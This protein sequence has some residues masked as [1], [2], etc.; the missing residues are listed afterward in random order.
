MRHPFPLSVSPT[1]L[2]SFHA[3]PTQYKY[4]YVLRLQESGSSRSIHLIAGSAFARGLE[5]MRD[6]YYNR[7]QPLATAIIL[8]FIALTLEYG[9]DLNETWA[10][11]DKSW[12][13]TVASYLNYLDRFPPPT[14]SLQPLATITT[15]MVEFTFSIPSPVLHPETGQPI[16]IS[17]RMDWVGTQGS[18]IWGVD[19]KTTK[20]IGAGWATNWRLRGQF[21]CYAW[22][23]REY[24]YKAQGIWVR[25]VPINAKASAEQIQEAMVPVKEWK[26]EMWVQQMTR[27]L[28]RMKECWRTD[29]WDQ[30]LGKSCTS[31]QQLENGHYIGGCPFQMLCDTPDPEPWISTFERKPEKN[32]KGELVHVKD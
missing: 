1:A 20:T 28:E 10:D 22:A 25:G 13:N 32:L 18:L 19:E 3:C 6:A 21:M 29:A 9:P 12:F 23:L 15:R 4:S 11:H 31:F 26:L 8:G 17:G 30:D 16:L 5:V 7:D 24:G 2:D 27:Y 14:D